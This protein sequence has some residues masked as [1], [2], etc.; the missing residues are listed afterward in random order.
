[1]EIVIVA[2][3]EAEYVKLS[4]KS[5]RMFADIEELSVIVVDNGSKDGLGEWARTQA[6]ITYVYM[7]EGRMPFGR[8]VNQV[9]EALRLHGDMLLMRAC[10]M[11]T[12]HCLFGMLQ[13]LHE[14]AD[15]GAAGP[16]S[17]GLAHSQKKKVLQIMKRLSGGC[18]VLK[19]APVKRWQGSIM[20]RYYSGGKHWSR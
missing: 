14:N 13:T 6:D 20:A 2:D 12:P 18:S 17:N 16:V 5:I 15:T 8:A 9:R 4:V 11:M 10:F 3:N 1:M 7:D 19:G